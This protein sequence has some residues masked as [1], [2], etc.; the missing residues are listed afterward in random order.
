MRI[1]GIL[2]LSMLTSICNDSMVLAQEKAQA[3]QAAEV[4]PAAAA[5]AAV[6]EEQAKKEAATPEAVPVA[7]IEA[8]P[9]DQVPTATPVT[10][11]VPTVT[12]A[13][14][15]IPTPAPEAAPAAPAEAPPT[16]QVPTVTPAPEAEPP[17]IEEPVTPPAAAPEVPTEEPAVPEVAAPEVVPAAPAEAPKIEEPVT[18]PEAV[19]EV[20]TEEPTVPV[21]E[22]PGIDTLD[23]EEPQGNWLYKRVWW[24]RAETKYEKI[25]SVVGKIL[26]ARMAFF[27]KRAELDKSVLD[28]FYIKV[29]L[30]QGALQE[31]VSR[32]I[33]QLEQER[34][35]IGMLE[36]PERDVLTK[37]EE[38]KKALE[39]IKLDIQGIN[40]A[41]NSVDD[42]LMK[43]MDQINRVR[44]FEQE[45]WKNFKEIA[46]VLDDKKA[47]ELFYKV[48]GAL[49]NVNDVLHYLQESFVPSFNKLVT[50]LKE[51]VERVQQAVQSLKEKG[52][53][54]KKQTEQL[55]EEKPKPPTPV[56]PEEE[57]EK[58]Q[59]GFIAQYLVNPVI[60]TVSFVVTVFK[61]T[62]D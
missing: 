58:P 16:D 13:P 40:K 41:D 50:T 53:D 15:E 14:G 44:G 2:L 23:L 38:E 11:Q 24:E 43:L 34:E 37:L 33:T 36:A 18:P 7:P 5:Q 25:R 47:R 52:V 32:L 29:G 30:D 12:P 22:I 28:P 21:D 26:E 48:D 35:K 6:K 55:T 19:P 4:T 20:P 49:R 31:V 42:A 57:E 60:S 39:Q 10:D 46:R 62:F 3:K 56:E 9:I 54:L 8:P 1:L 61:T 27:A 45:A 59:P 51:Q 17:K